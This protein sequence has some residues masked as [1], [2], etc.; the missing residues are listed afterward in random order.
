ML[1]SADDLTLYNKLMLE[2]YQG[3]RRRTKEYDEFY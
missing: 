2:K 3:L 1:K